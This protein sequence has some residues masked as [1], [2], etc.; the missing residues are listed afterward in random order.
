MSVTLFSKAQILSILKDKATEKL[1]SFGGSKLVNSV[2]REALT[3][4][5]KDCDTH[6]ILSPNKFPSANYINLCNT[7]KTENGY[8]LTPGFYEIGLKSFCLKAG[9][10]GPSK[11]DGYLYAPLKGPK[12]KIIRTILVNWE[13]HPEIEQ[14]DVQV[15]IWAII[16][17]TKIS[18]MSPEMQ[19]TA[20]KLL[21]DSDVK[22]INSFAMDY[23]TTDNIQKVVGNFPQAVQKV[24]EAENNIRQKLTNGSTSSY[25]EIEAIAMLAGFSNGQSE[26]EHGT[27]GLHPKGYYVA[28]F[29]SSYSHITV[30]IYVPD[31]VKE[32]YFSPAAE[33]AVPASTGSQRLGI[34]NVLD[35][36]Q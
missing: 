27:W 10:Y 11:G 4:N 1:V 15:L 28:Y 33:V 18:N 7:A 3:T 14:R 17:K 24:I 22:L 19:A 36:Q 20:F 9:T 8:R 12:E 35:C 6:N 26:I 29:P 2:S 30:K 31:T 23:L 34:S 25:Q 13:K 5:F 21:S 16:A 32:V